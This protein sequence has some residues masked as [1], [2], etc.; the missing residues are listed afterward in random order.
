[1]LADGIM[2]FPRQAL[3]FFKN[4]LLHPFIQFFRLFLR[5]FLG[6]FR[7]FLELLLHLLDPGQDIGHFLKEL[8]IL[9]GRDMPVFDRQQIIFDRLELFPPVQGRSDGGQ[10]GRPDAEQGKEHEE[11]DVEHFPLPQ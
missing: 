7:L 10:E 1:L 3:P 8:L 9:F 2:E 4:Q 6:D 11:R 5:Q